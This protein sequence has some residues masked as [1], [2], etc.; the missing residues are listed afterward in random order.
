MVLE[1]SD[2]EF[3]LVDDARPDIDKLAI[4]GGATL[5]IGRS[6]HGFIG[7]LGQC[8]PAGLCM[9]AADDKIG[10]LLDDPELP[11]F[12]VENWSSVE[13]LARTLIWSPLELIIRRRAAAERELDALFDEFARRLSGLR[14]R[15]RRGWPITSQ[16]N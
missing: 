9:P 15:A 13:A 6:M 2:G 4:V 5:Y 10:E 14:N 7:A 16:M 3:F 11:Q 8:R 1:A 12:R